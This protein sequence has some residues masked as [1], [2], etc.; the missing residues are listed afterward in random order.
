MVSLPGSD[1]F[2]HLVQRESEGH[3]KFLEQFSPAN[4]PQATPFGAS[5]LMVGL[6]AVTALAAVWHK[7]RDSLPY[8]LRPTGLGVYVLLVLVS[9][10][11][12]QSYNRTAPSESACAAIAESGELTPILTMKEFR[13]HEQLAGALPYDCILDNSENALFV[14]FKNLDG[15]LKAI[16]FERA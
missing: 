7:Y 8:C 4:E 10:V 15:S 11:Y 13:G 16:L 2:A 1:G 9:V 3:I 6:L 12:V 14:S 5:R